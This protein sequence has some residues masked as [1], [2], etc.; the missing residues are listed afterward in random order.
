VDITGIGSIFDFGSK[1]LDKVFPNKDDADKAK[2]A[3]LQMQQQ[4]AFKELEIQLELAKGQM[5][6]NE[7]EAQSPSLFVSGW[8]PAVGWV[9]VFAYAFNYLL[10]PI[11]NWLAVWL[12][13]NAPKILMLETGELTTL[14]FGM[15]GIGGLRTFE[16]LKGK[17]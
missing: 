16:K 4:G 5:A 2:L 6:I 13:P 1:L 11:A 15:L 3:M 8:R 17:A 14:L 7:K 12:D 10:M 9:C